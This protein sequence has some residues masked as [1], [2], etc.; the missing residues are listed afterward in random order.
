MVVTGMRGTFCRCRKTDL[1]QAFR[2]VRWT[3]HRVFDDPQRDLIE[4]IERA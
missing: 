1:S 2:R 3:L 4:L